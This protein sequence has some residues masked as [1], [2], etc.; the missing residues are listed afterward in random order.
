MSRKR[1]KQRKARVEAVPEDILAEGSGPVHRIEQDAIAT[2]DDVVTT[3]DIATTEDVVTADDVVATPGSAGARSEPEPEDAPPKRAGR[4]RRS[5]RP[6][7]ETTPDAE[8]A[9]GDAPP[10]A[11]RPDPPADPPGSEPGSEPGSGIDAADRDGA[12]AVAVGEPPAQGAGPGEGG[13]RADAAV[14][15]ARAEGVTAGADPATVD[16]VAGGDAA[17][18]AA[19]EPPL[20]DA[21]E[22]E[23][24]EDELHS[25]AAEGAEHAADDQARD[26]AGDGDEGDDAADGDDEGADEGAGVFP[27]SAATMD[28]VQ[29]KH[30]VEALIFASDRPLTVQRLRQLTRVS[31]VRRLEQAL[32]EIAE[33]YRERGL[34][35][36]QVSGG[37]QFR[38]RTQFSPW[39][40][41]LIAGRPVRLSRAQLETLAI[42]AYRQPITRPE[43][44]DIRGVDSTAT[45]KLLIDRALIRVLGKREEVGRPMLYGTTKEFLDFFSLGDLRELP[46]LREYSELT[47]ESRKVMSD[48]LGIAA[49]GSDGP[50]GG[51]ED[52]DDGSGNGHGG[53]GH[54]GNGHGGNGHGG[55]GHGGYGGDD[56]GAGGPGGLGGSGGGPSDD[57]ALAIAAS[58]GDDPALGA[59]EADADPR[60]LAEAAALSG[61]PNV[62][63]DGVRAGAAEDAGASAAEDAGPVRAAQSAAGASS[64]EDAG[65]VRAAQSPAGASAAPDAGAV[66][67]AADDDPAANH[68]SEDGELADA[69]APD[70]APTD[71]VSPAL[72]AFWAASDAVDR[73]NAAVGGG[74]EDAPADTW[75]DP[76]LDDSLDDLVDADD[77]EEPGEGTRSNAG[78]RAAE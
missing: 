28:A 48:R 56:G 58:G 63:E 31:D 60:S 47:A 78:P 24:A 65:P 69:D 75:F 7:R 46:T 72:S 14:S 61:A 44:D 4:T 18:A 53:N 74:E 37:Y 34:V 39:V 30:L 41:Q 52:P 32:S 68:S 64:E 1:G 22:G 71:D 3:E 45:L 40:Q 70:R 29:L 76:S 43:I 27:T 6:G 38:T 20:D 54:G 12:G 11:D 26:A 2:V 15:G 21:M 50:G 42:I 9:D 51:G 67:T 66:S 55:N 16:A 19:G 36:Q 8:D 62:P 49:D 57:G 5:R 10:G 59:A 77:L 17:A 23:S 13:G 73:S 35:L 33:D 25:A